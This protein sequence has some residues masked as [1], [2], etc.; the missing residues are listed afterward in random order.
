[1]RFSCAGW[2]ALLAIASLT[3]GIWCGCSPSAP[4]ADGASPEPT[5]TDPP[6]VQRP[7]SPAPIDPPDDRATQSPEFLESGREFVEKPLMFVSAPDGASLLEGFLKTAWGQV[8]FEQGYGAIRRA[9]TSLGLP[10]ITLEE[11]QDLARGAFYV[12]F[13]DIDLADDESFGTV[14]ILGDTADPDR[15]EGLLESLWYAAGREPGRRIREATNLGVRCRILELEGKTKEARLSRV[16]SAFLVVL[17]ASR[18]RCKSRFAHLL[19]PLVAEG[20]PGVLRDP[21]FGWNGRPDHVPSGA[22]ASMDLAGLIDAGMQ[23]M[24]RRNEGRGLQV[25]S[26]L[27]LGDLDALHIGAT[28]R[29]EGLELVFSLA[30]KEQ[31]PVPR[32]VAALLDSHGHDLLDLVPETA[33]TAWSILVPPARLHDLGVRFYATVSSR[34]G[35][36]NTFRRLME[37]SFKRNYGFDLQH[38]LLD[39]LGPRVA[40]FFPADAAT[41]ALPGESTTIGLVIPTS[42]GEEIRT[43]LERSTVPELRRAKGSQHVLYRFDPGL[44]EDYWF[45]VL[46]DALVASQS[47]AV[48]TDI[49][50]VQTGKVTSLLDSG[51]LDQAPARTPPPFILKYGDS[52]IAAREFLGKIERPTAAFDLVTLA[53]QLGGGEQED[54]QISEIPTT[55]ALRAWFSR[56]NVTTFELHGRHLVIRVSG[57]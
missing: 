43:A 18:E 45:A 34:G 26:F 21:T 47:E 20:V 3:C 9:K 19:A 28:F 13:S 4:S 41:R 24:R 39:H 22:T 27:R 49:V 31:A 57:P 17:S 15:V 16:G 33:V 36:T 50:N 14:A 42:S 53:R 55:E 6:S 56:P 2:G 8:L 32:S 40:I 1:M 52:A 29:G 51:L 48:V 37:R 35:D 30:W 23:R 5:A 54:A 7:P 11:V 25:F 12:A 10:S 44:G 46:D 38:D